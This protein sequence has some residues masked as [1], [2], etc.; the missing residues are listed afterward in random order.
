MNHVKVDAPLLAFDNV[1]PVEVQ[2][3]VEAPVVAPAQP[4]EKKIEE[5]VEEQKV[6]AEEEQKAP[7]EDV[8]P[9]ISEKEIAMM[10]SQQM[11]EKFEKD[12]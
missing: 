6:P 8:K 5:P 7:A 1:E 12:D 9:E 10:R 2:P 4:V 3:V 11:L